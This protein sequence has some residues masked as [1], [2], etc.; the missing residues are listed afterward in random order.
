MKTPQK[1]NY[2]CRQPFSVQK[3]KGLHTS[4]L[5]A[6]ISLEKKNLLIIES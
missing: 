3:N 6:N 5:L 4:N 1:F 2:L